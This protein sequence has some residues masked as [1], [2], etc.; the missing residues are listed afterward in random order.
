M[1]CRVQTLGRG[2][3]SL[4]ASIRVPL[5]PRRLSK[6][7]CRARFVSA[8][9]LYVH[10]SPPHKQ[11]GLRGGNLADRPERLAGVSERFVGERPLLLGECVLKVCS[12][13]LCVLKRV[14]AG[15]RIRANPPGETEAA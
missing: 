12:R 13:K 1:A 15:S 10:F 5:A 7:A 6:V 4:A 14:T 2:E 9:S 3:Q 11:V 8:G